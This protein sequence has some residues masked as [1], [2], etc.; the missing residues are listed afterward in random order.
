MT[1]PITIMPV[2]LVLRV[3]AGRRGGSEVPPNSNLGPFVEPILL[4]VGLPPGNPWCAAYVYD[5][6]SIALPGL[7]PGPRTGGCQVLADY[8]RIHSV[9]FPGPP[10]RGDIFLLWE[11][12]KKEQAWRFGH[13]GFVTRVNADGSVLTNEG[14]T[15]G[16][17]SREGWLV[18]EKTRVL[19]DKDRLFRWP[20]LLQ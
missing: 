5:T 10:V 11:F 6:G 8:A 2:D 18:G 7:W 14:N 20:L 13:T 9:L 1:A 12:I 15:N 17:G 19:G 3:A 4:S 16:A